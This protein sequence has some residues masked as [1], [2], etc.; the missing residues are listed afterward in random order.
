M[1]AIRA[2]FHRILPGH[3]LCCLDTIQ[4]VQELLI[5]KVEI[6]LQLVS[7]IDVHAI[8]ETVDDHLLFLKRG[9]IIQAVLFMQ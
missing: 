7:A 9:I 8:D 1:K 6:N 3:F 2:V 5:I 4:P